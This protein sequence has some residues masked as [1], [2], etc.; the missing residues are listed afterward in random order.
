MNQRK[1]LYATVSGIAGL[2]L[3]GWL[4]STLSADN[5]NEKTIKQQALFKE[6]DLFVRDQASSPVGLS[7]D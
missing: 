1:K 4:I 3:V 7:R 2:M 6:A 5:E